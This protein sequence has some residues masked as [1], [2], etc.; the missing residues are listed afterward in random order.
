MFGSK[1]VLLPMAEFPQPEL[2][3]R[4]AALS[5]GLEQFPSG[6]PCPWPLGRVF[7]ELVKQAKRLVTDDP[8]VRGMRL[9][10]E[11]ADG[12]SDSSDTLV[13]TVRALITQVR[14]ALDAPSNS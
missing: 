7:N 14:A 13:G 9:L 6:A 3:R 12:D 10:E 2:D 1:S 4:L 8:I 11:G 5:N